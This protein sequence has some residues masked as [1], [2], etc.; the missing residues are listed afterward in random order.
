[1]MDG[2]ETL[3]NINRTMHPSGADYMRLFHSIL[4]GLIHTAPAFVVETKERNY[5]IRNAGLHIGLKGEVL[6]V[7]FEVNE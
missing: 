5:V 6:G 2:L 1:M 4:N 3:Q 7:V